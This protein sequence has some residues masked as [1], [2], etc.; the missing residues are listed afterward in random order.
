[1]ED[2]FIIKNIIIQGLKSGYIKNLSAADISSLDMYDGKWRLSN[3]T[4]LGSTWDIILSKDFSK[5]MWGSEGDN[6]IQQMVIMSSQDRLNFLKEFVVEN[7]VHEIAEAEAKS[8]EIYEAPVNGLMTAVR[9][10]MSRLKEYSIDLYKESCQDTYD[11]LVGIVYKN[12]ITELRANDFIIL[13][14]MDRVMAAKLSAYLNENGKSSFTI[15]PEC[16]VDDFTH[17]QGCSIDIKTGDWLI[18]QNEGC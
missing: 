7:K 14:A 4:D 13:N 8:T 1:M 5:H 11:K 2:F 6:K 3:G 10:S 9:E 15:C 18:G 17:V 16:S 12:S